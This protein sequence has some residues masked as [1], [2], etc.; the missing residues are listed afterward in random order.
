MR[1]CRLLL[2]RG[3]FLTSPPRRN[4]WR[5]SF[6][7]LLRCVLTL[8]KCVDRYIA[9]QIHS[10]DGSA[11]SSIDEDQVMY[12]PDDRLEAVVERMFERC[13]EDKEYKQVSAFMIG[14][15]GRP[16]E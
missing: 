6:V 5:L 8:A 1:R 13:L 7:W 14:T 15:Y 9:T 4:L 3:S 10:Q 2:E 12:A 11:E 16:L